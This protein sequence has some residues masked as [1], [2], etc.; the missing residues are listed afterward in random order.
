MEKKIGFF[1]KSQKTIS[2]NTPRILPDGKGERWLRVIVDA[3]IFITNTAVND[4]YINQLKNSDY[5]LIEPSRLKTWMDNRINDSGEK[6]IVTP[7][8]K[9]IMTGVLRNIIDEVSLTIKY[10][11]IRR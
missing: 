4:S 8:L 7:D 3:F 2:H 1:T 10:S 6:F 11:D 9:F 5:L